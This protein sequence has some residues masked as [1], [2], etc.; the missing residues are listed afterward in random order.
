M[1]FVVPQFIDVEDKI[2]GPFS[3]RQFIIMIV[4]VVVLFLAFRF[5]DIAL[6]ILEAIFIVFLVLLFAFFRVNGRP[7]HLFVVNIVQSTRK[8]HKRVWKRYVAPEELQLPKVQMPSQKKTV[9]KQPLSASRLTELSLVVDT[10]GA[11]RQEE[12]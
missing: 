3:V 11:Y 7:F 5:A 1:Q 4:G 2:F 8:P 6:F 12:N 10:G 9:L